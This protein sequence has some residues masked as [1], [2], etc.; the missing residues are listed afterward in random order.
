MARE[1]RRVRKPHEPDRRY[2]DR[3]LALGFRTL[4]EGLVEKGEVEVVDSLWGREFVPKP[5]DEP[6][7]AEPEPPPAERPEPEP[8]APG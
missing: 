8:P 7:P 3:R 1:R 4:V 6:E 2:G 5:P